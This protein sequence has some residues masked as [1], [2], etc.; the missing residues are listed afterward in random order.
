MD[1]IDNFDFDKL[2]HIFTERF[3]VAH[4]PDNNNAFKNL[5]ISTDPI[6]LRVFGSCPELIEFH[7]DDDYNLNRFYNKYHNTTLRD[8]MILLWHS[9]I[10]ITD[11]LKNELFSELAFDKDV[12]YEDI[13]N[14]IDNIME[15]Y[16]QLS[17]KEAQKQWE[18]ESKNK[19]D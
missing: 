12:S 5:K 16:I 14:A 6:C 3:L 9:S 17:A 19:S 15:R 10:G 8:I 7:I 13:S 18:K 11:T 2:D 1:R 4:Y